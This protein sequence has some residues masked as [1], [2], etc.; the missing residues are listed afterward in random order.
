MQPHSVDDAV[1]MH[2]VDTV[3]HQSVDMQCEKCGGDAFLAT[4]NGQG[5]SVRSVEERRV[6]DTGKVPLAPALPPP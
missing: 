1:Q 3:H 6:G 5:R 2:C 4:H